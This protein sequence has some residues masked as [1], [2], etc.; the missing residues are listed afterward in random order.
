M[1]ASAGHA[2]GMMSIAD[3]ITA[4]GKL[5]LEEDDARTWLWVNP[6]PSLYWP[7]E[8]D[9]LQCL[10]RNFGNVIGHNQAIWW[11]DLSGKWQ[12]QRPVH[13]GQQQDRHRNIQRQHRQ[14]TTNHPPGRFDI[15]SGILYVAQGQ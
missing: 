1:T 10:R 2:N 3:S 9:T 7:T 14:P 8:W 4:A 12:F 13:L 11:M 6:E 15:R 5:Y